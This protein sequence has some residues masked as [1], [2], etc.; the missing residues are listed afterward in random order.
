MK[1]KQ[2]ET[3]LPEDETAIKA[4]KKIQRLIKQKGHKL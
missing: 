3:E 2:A 4:G 1:I